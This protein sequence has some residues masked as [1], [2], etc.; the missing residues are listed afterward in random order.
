MKIKM[1]SIYAKYN[2]NLP[3]TA[4]KNLTIL[5]DKNNI[6]RAVN[7][8][9][10]II[11]QGDTGC[12]K[13]TQF[14]QMIL[15]DA[16]SKLKYCNIVVTQPR[17]IAAINVAKQVASER[18]CDLGSLVGY[19]IGLDACANDDTRLLY[20]TT[21]V[22]LQKLIRARSLNTY[23]HI[24]LDEVHERTEEMDFL[25]IVVRKLLWS[26]SRNVK[27]ILM[28]AT[29][30]ADLFSKY[31]M[32]PRANNELLAPIIKVNPVL[33]PIYKV[34]EFYIDNLLDKMKPP[35]VNLLDPVIENEMYLCALKLCYACDTLDKEDQINKFTKERGSILIF[36]PGVPEIDKMQDILL[37]D[38]GEHG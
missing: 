3:Q 37:T 7:A 38:T 4:N 2:F 33:N 32:I 6:M 26:N 18:E 19:Q 13:S 27:I 12:G 5:K 35:I 25:M 22:L 20:C 15:D 34:S 11:L 30:E 17:R 21:G 14:P 16:H 36:L 28:S 10:V 23:T 29:I 8:N 1:D 31:F 9:P 24:V